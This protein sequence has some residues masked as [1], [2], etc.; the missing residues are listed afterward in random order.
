MSR[1]ADGGGRQ[2]ARRRHLVVWSG[3]SCTMATRGVVSAG[4]KRRTNVAIAASSA[5][6]R[7]PTRSPHQRHLSDGG[8]NERASSGSAA[9]HRLLRV[10]LQHTGITPPTSGQRRH[11]RSR[12]CKF[13]HARCA[14]IHLRRVHAWRRPCIAAGGAAY[15]PTS[16]RMGSTAGSDVAIYDPPRRKIY[17]SW[18]MDFPEA[19]RRVNNINSGMG[20]TV[21]TTDRSTASGVACPSGGPAPS[22]QEGTGCG[23]GA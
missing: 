1:A 20:P 5:H 7:A 6:R 21:N 15:R 4:A 22:P 13:A 12:R 10:S 14:Q 19:K 2:R 18:P 16:A 3:F 23:G 11:H 17:A 9:R 8:H